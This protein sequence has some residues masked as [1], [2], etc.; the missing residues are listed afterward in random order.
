MLLMSEDVSKP[1]KLVRTNWFLIQDVLE[2]EKEDSQSL[3]TF[4]KGLPGLDSLVADVIDGAFDVGE[5]GL[6]IALLRSNADANIVT[7]CAG[8]LSSVNQ[9]SWAKGLKSQGDLL[10][11]VIE[12]KAQGANLTLSVDYFDALIEYAKNVS[13]GLR[14]VL[15]V[16][17][18]H[19]LFALL[20]ADQQE[21]L[22]RR[23]YEVLESSNGG[24]S[25]KFFD[26]FGDM[27][28]NRDLLANAQRFIHQVCRP[29]LDAGNARGLAWVA[30]IADSEPALLSEHSDQAAA[31]DFMV[32]IRQRLT[33]I[34]EDDPMLPHLKRIGTA[35]GIEREASDTE[36]ETQSED[37][38]A[39]SE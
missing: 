24:A 21:L 11:L 27:L 30:D 18:W 16:E 36:L 2:K 29:I 20:S 34:P 10:D 35:L 13:E 37:E 6:Y 8:G 25:P 32:R 17:S 39:T 22:P 31:N 5:S 33:D 19:E 28:S 12:L 26:L 3:E 9:D 14:R 38:G 7:W 1:I 23:V 15:P 4:L